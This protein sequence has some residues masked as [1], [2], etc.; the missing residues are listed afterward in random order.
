MGVTSAAKT[1]EAVAAGNREGV[2]EA[3]ILPTAPEEDHAGGWQGKQGGMPEMPPALKQLAGGWET[4]L[5]PLPGES[6]RAFA[7]F[8]V[9]IDLGPRRSIDAAAWQYSRQ[10]KGAT[11]GQQRGSKKRAPGRITLWS[12]RFFWTDRARA[13]DAHLDNLGRAIHVNAVLAMRERHAREAFVL[14]ALAMR[15]FDLFAEA[16][17]KDPEAIKEMTLCQAQRLYLAAAKLEAQSR[18]EALKLSRELLAA[19]Q[20]RL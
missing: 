20:P 10:S 8:R 1:R 17:Q 12:S 11:A 18:D 13:W 15:R 16:V 14:A 6:A 9:Y 4:I 3:P 2:G 19:S 5:V 7:A